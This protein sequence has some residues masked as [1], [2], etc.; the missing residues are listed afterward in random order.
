MPTTTPWNCPGRTSPTLTQAESTLT[1]ISNIWTAGPQSPTRAAR[2]ATIPASTKLTDTSS[3]TA[4]AWMPEISG[5]LQ[6]VTGSGSSLCARSTEP[7]KQPPW[8][9][10][11]SSERKAPRPTSRT[12][13][14]SWRE[15]GVMFCSTSISSTGPI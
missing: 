4:R 6:A 9:P 2:V 8:R 10:S 3:Y 14:R 11:S 5:T 13:H 7:P 15:P 12:G 1:V